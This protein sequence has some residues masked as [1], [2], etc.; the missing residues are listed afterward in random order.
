MPL[1]S[2]FNAH[3]LPPPTHHKPNPQNR[4]H[5]PISHNTSLPRKHPKN[6]KTKRQGR[7]P[8]SFTTKPTRTHAIN[9][10]TNPRTTTT[11]TNKTA[12]AAAAGPAQRLPHRAQAAP[13]RPR[14]LPR[15]RPLPV[16][17]LFFLC[18]YVCIYVG[19]MGVVCK[20]VRWLGSKHA[21][22]LTRPRQI[23]SNH[24]PRCNGQYKP[25]TSCWT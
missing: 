14:G 10:N 19:V 22:A 23:L 25:G 16:R 9:T 6:P 1:S 20:L 15:H 24:Q 4:Q 8:Q 17:V 2:I 18:Q 11:T 5:I 21:T 13:P 3:T 12:G 7:P